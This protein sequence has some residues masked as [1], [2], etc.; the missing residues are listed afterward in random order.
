MPSEMRVK[1]ANLRSGE[2]SGEVYTDF[3]VFWG[4][5]IALIA[6]LVA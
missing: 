3:Q 5:I 2:V 1:R 4:P 6:L